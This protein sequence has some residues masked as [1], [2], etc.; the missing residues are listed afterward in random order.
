MASYDEEAMAA[1]IKQRTK[2][3]DLVVECDLISLF[4]A[5]E[6]KPRDNADPT[7][8][9]NRLAIIDKKTRGPSTMMP[10]AFRVLLGAINAAG[11]VLPPG[12]AAKKA[13]KVKTEHESGDEED[14]N[15]EDDADEEEK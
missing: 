10:L 7:E 5:F 15:E 14:G 9:L 1:A 3:L 11:F 13:T 12:K 8:A 6:L 2:E 4:Q